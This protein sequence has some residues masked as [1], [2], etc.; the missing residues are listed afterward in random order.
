MTTAVDKESTVEMS[1][2]WRTKGVF[3]MK[4]KNVIVPVESVFSVN[5]YS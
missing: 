3:L 5:I 1:S 2:E 4:M